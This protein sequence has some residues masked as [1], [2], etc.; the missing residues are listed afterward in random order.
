MAAATG[1]KVNVEKKHL[2]PS[3][4]H[5]KFEFLD[6]SNPFKE[7]ETEV[8]YVKTGSDKYDTFFMKSAKFHGKIVLTNKFLDS[9]DSM[10]ENGVV[11][12][13]VTGETLGMLASKNANLSMKQR[14]Q[15]TAMML[16]GKTGQIGSKFKS[17]GKSKVEKVQKQLFEEYP[18]LEMVAKMYA[19]M[20]KELKPKKLKK[21]TKMLVESGQKLAESAKSDFSD[22]KARAAMVGK[23]LTGT[24]KRLED[25]SKRAMKMPEK[26]KKT[27]MS[28]KEAI[29]KAKKEM[30]MKQ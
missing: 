24:V 20:Q 10:I 3:Q 11:T 13:L 8:Q 6:E 22:N 25:M 18:K 29:K 16:S 28:L 27:M 17:V 5:P 23:E 1:Q 7:G 30:A 19:P 21:Q 2:K 12:E 15:I 26:L 4:V 9:L 14:R